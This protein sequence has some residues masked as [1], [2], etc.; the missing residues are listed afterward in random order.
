[1]AVAD[2]LLSAARLCDAAAQAADDQ[3]NNMPPRPADPAA[4]AVWDNQN[5]HLQHNIG[6]LGNLA[7]SLA[8]AAVSDVLAA[9]WPNLQ[10]LS[11]VTASAQASIAQ[12]NSISAALNA[13]AAVISFGVSIAAFV[14]APSLDGARSVAS[15]FDAAK[16]ALS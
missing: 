2:D 10:G 8:A 9:Q 3:Q 6:T 14:A 12:I 5:S 16:A 15:A 1:M 7:S 11:E 4:A 13:L